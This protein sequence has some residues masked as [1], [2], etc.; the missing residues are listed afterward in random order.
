MKWF[1]LLL[2]LLSP[3]ITF[4]QQLGKEATTTLRPSLYISENQDS[5]Y[6]FTKKQL[7]QIVKNFTKWEYDKMEIAT[8]DKMI[9][10]LQGKVESKG[11]I[12]TA[13]Y[14]EIELNEQAIAN[15]DTI[16]AMQETM[17]A[18]QDQALA[19]KDNE[20]ARHKRGKRRLTFWGTVT[21]TVAI[22]LILITGGR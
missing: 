2:A 6:C 3:S 13:L 9:T 7:R 17:L 14:Q 21:T 19:L 4:G 18:N 20:I 12:V 16:I 15:R 8:K 10:E 5:S 22:T 11:A 1:P